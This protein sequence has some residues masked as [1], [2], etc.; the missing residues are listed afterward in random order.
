MLDIM[1]AARVSSFTPCSE[2]DAAMGI[3]PYMHSGE[4]TPSRLAGITPSQPILR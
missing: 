1:N 2:N 3:V 4:A